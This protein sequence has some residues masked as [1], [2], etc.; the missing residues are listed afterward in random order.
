MREMFAP[1]MRHFVQYLGAFHVTL[2]S[3]A[4]PPDARGLKLKVDSAPCGNKA[5]SV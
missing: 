1:E 2:K 4:E 5:L 3:G